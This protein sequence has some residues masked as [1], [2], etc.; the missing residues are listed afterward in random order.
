V[1]FELRA[2]GRYRVV[3][4]NSNYETEPVG[5]VEGRLGLDHEV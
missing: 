4:D 3:I 1:T 5:P 2:P